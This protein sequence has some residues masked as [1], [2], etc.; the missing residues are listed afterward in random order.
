MQ[1]KIVAFGPAETELYAMV[2][3]SAQSL[4]IQ[5]YAHDLS[6]YMAE[7]GQVCSARDSPLVQEVR[8]SGRIS[9]KKCFGEKS[10]SDRLTKCVTAK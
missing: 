5:A 10:P 7:C 6:V 2:A 8:V 1:H 3:A 9:Y 4:A